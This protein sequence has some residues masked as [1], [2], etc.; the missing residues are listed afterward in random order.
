MNFAGSAE[1]VSEGSAADVEDDASAVVA[2][3]LAVA[4]RRSRDGINDLK[5]DMVQVLCKRALHHQDVWKCCNSVKS[6]FGSVADCYKAHT[7]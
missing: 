2:K 1:E 3:C 5:N 4:G 6:H 7:G